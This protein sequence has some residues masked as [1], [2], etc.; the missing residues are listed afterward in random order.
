M[1]SIEDQGKNARPDCSIRSGFSA[2]F[3]LPTLHSKGVPMYKANII[4]GSSVIYWHQQACAFS[5]APTTATGASEPP[6][7]FR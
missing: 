6:T 7:A 4:K 5:S 2:H 3:K 1:S